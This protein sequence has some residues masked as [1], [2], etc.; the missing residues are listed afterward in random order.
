VFSR[1]INRNCDKRSGKYQA[2][3]A[4]RKCEKRHREK[5]KKINLTAALKEYI[6]K[7]LIK[8][9]SPEQ[10]SGTSKKGRRVMCIHRVDLSVYLEG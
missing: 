5:P 6:D 9:F 4:Q 1:E 7:L 3:L 8:K 2:D 10:I